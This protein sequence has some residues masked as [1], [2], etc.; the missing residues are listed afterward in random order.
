[1]I[2]ANSVAF[3]QIPP[4]TQADFET[5]LSASPVFG[6]AVLALMLHQSLPV[7]RRRC[8]PC[9]GCVVTRYGFPGQVSQLIHLTL[10]LV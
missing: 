5:A 6:L 8:A 2:S 7:E 4:L 1:M 3:R 10:A 9:A